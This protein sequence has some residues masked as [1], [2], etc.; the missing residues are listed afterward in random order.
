[1]ARRAHS[2]RMEVQAL[3]LLSMEM[4]TTFTPVELAVIAAIHDEWQHPREDLERWIVARNNSGRVLEPLLDS[5]DMQ[6]FQSD[7][8]IALATIDDLEMLFM[9]EHCAE[10]GCTNYADDGEGYDGYCGSHADAREANGV[11][12]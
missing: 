6:Q 2:T 3:Y 7:G 5:T 4:E 9:D 1:M 12:V 11:Y 10:P 8:T